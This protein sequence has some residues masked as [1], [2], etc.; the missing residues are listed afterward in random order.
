MRSFLVTLALLAGACRPAAPVHEYSL[1]GQVLAVDR[2]RS[3]VTVRHRDI[4]GFMPGMT[5]PFPVRDAGI[6][7]RAR[8]GDLVEAT[9]SVQGSDVWISRLTVTGTAPVTAAPAT[10]LE[11]GDLVADAALVDQ[12]GKPTRVA[13]LKGHPSIVS[14]VYTRCPLP[15]YC[16]TVEAKLGSV[17]EAIRK[18]PMLSGT[19][20][21]TLT[22]DPAYDTPRV[23]AQHAKWRGADPGI[24]RFATGPESVID[25]FGRQFG[26]AVSRTSAEPTGIEHNLRTVVLAPDL[27]IVT[28]LTGSDWRVGDVIDALRSASGK[29]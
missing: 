8:P 9:L 29:S 2:A 17:Q 11:P 21:L 23:L 10:G 20:I 4:E 13:D 16:P 19:K 12:D 28:V 15:E 5:M 1:V 25:G 22:L 7:D 6:L 27:R 24:W 14:F 26:V 3:R 18:D